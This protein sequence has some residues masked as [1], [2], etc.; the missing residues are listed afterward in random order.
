MAVLCR[1][2]CD[3]VNSI[4]D[5]GFAIEFDSKFSLVERANISATLS[6]TGAPSSAS[7]EGASSNGVADETNGHHSVPKA[8]SV[9]DKEDGRGDEET[10]SSEGEDMEGYES[11]TSCSSSGEDVLVVD[12][13]EEEEEKGAELGEE[14]PEDDEESGSVVDNNIQQLKV[15]YCSLFV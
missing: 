8:N 3:T 10:V 6:P 5:C 9:D 7:A 1:E 12:S 14:L 11:D 13:E 15:C 4:P 2:L